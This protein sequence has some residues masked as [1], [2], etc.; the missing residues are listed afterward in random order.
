[1]TQ[2]RQDR[3]GW[4]TAMRWTARLLTL[5][6]AGLFVA[7]LL[8]SG[9]KVFS[10]L[11]WSSPQGIPMLIALVVAIV[12]VGLAWRW[13]MLGGLMAVVGAAAIM[14]LVCAGS[15]SD[16]LLCSVFFTLPLLAAGALYLGCCWRMRM[17]TKKA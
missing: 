4:T 7:F 15:G 9:T 16:M 14:A 6:A 3:T 11:S 2:V 5:A 17:V 12:G 10:A 8:V 1:M 13:E